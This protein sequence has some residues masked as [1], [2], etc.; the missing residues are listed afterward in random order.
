MKKKFLFVLLGFLVWK[1][2]VSVKMGLRVL[3]WTNTQGRLT[4]VPKSGGG[5]D[6]S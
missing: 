3:S 2:R 4:G 5:W 1:N 6:H